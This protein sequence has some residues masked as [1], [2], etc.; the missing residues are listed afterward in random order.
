LKY[1]TCL[2]CH[3]TKPYKEFGRYYKSK[4]GRQ[5][6]CKPC[7]AQ[8]RAENKPRIKFNSASAARRV[9]VEVLAHYSLHGFPQCVECEEEDIVCLSIDHIDGRGVDHRKA[10]KRA[11]LPFYYWLRR[12]DF[13]EGYQTLCMNCQFRKRAKNREYGI[14]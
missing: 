12:S 13:P 5:S 3:Q 8:W 4:D 6:W 1:K 9:K 2:H 7:F 11:G 10:L 14:K